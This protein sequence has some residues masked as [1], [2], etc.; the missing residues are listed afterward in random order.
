MAKFAHTYLHRRAKRD[1]FERRDLMSFMMASYVAKSAFA[2][3]RYVDFDDAVATLG[4]IRDSAMKMMFPYV[5]IEEKKRNPER[6]EDYEEYFD[7]LDAIEAEK[8]AASGGNDI[9][10]T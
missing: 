1:F 3:S 2:S 10:N 5:S 8:K 4:S 6:Y 7:E 9:I